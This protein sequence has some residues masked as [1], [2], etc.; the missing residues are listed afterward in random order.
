[1]NYLLQISDEAKEEVD[2]ESTVD[3]NGANALTKVSTTQVSN[4]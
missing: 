4:D 3:E 1:M 2:D